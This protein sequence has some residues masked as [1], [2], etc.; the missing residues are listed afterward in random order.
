[1]PRLNILLAAALLA[2]NAPAL[3]APKS[4]T[5]AGW[6]ALNA[7]RSY[8]AIPL[9]SDDTINPLRGYYRWQNQELVP[10]A[11]PARDAYRRYYWKDVETAQG[12]YNFSAILNDLAAAKS[13][14]RKFAFRLRMMAGYDDNQLYAPAY[15][16]NHASCTA[17]CG[18]WAD[19]D[20]ATA[21][22]TFIPDWNDAWLQQRARAMLAALAAALGPDNPDIAWIDVGMYGQYG[23]WAVR[24]SAYASPP[25]GITPASNASKRE[26][27]RMHF[28]A[29]PNQQ[30]VM[31][32][33]YSNKDAM[34]YGMLEQTITSKP[35]GLRADCLSRY[36][37]FDQWTNRPAE[38]AAF[39]S[40]WQKAPVVSEFCPFTSGDP[41]DNPATARQ[42]A[43]LFHVSLVS[44]GNFQTQLPDAQR[45]PGLTAAE[46]NDLLMLGR[47]SGYRYAVASSTVN[48]TSAGVLTLTTQLRNDGSAPAYE[49]WTVNAELVNSAGA[50]VWSA[51]TAANLKSLAGGGTSAAWQNSWT[52]PALPVGDYTL[53]LAARDG[54]ASPRAP[55]KWTIHER[56]ADGTLAVAT[57]KRR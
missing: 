10:Q 14:G 23:E 25:A 36:G 28:D 12:Q 37:Y 51:P 22:L 40:Q 1:M 35:V 13:Q 32:I 24:S 29:F 38:W 33:P 21:G 48:L 2:A 41:Q 56:A 27:A 5:S 54:S 11:G 8:S 47:E 26:F 49:A 15:I 52:L 16:V 20:A 30:H 3:A 42:Q 53:R 6:T 50:V 34:T 19:T 44:N 55:L 17:G 7:S 4:L 18:F 9:A 43:A 46:Q 57:L 39:A 31:F 45:W